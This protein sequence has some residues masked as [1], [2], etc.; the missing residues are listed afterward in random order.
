MAK[1]T[2]TFEDQ[3]DG[4]VKVV[5]EPS[6]EQMMQ[7]LVSGSELTAS[8]GY[9]VNALNSVRQAAQTQKDKLAVTIPIIS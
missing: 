7:F 5:C 1:V 8:Q 2:I 9:A 3:P 6:F 4:K